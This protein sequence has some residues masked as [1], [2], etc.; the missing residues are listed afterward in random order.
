MKSLAPFST[1]SLITHNSKGDASKLRGSL[2][3]DKQKD[4][5]MNHFTI[6]GPSANVQSTMQSLTY[7]PVSAQAYR[8][9]KP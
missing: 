5:K 3:A 2:N 4:L 1:T 9:A 8:D 7:R 6:G